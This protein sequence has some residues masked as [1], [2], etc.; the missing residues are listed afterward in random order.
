[1]AGSP[2]LRRRHAE[3]SAA[4][5]RIPQARAFPDPT[6][7]Y[8]ISPWTVGRGSEPAHE[9]TLSQPLQWPGKRGARSDAA[10]SD[11][12]AVAGDLGEEERHHLLE[13]RRIFAK[14]WFA[15]RRIALGGQARTLLERARDQALNAAAAGGPTAAVLEGEMALSELERIVL[16][17]EREHLATMAEINALAGRAADATV[18][19]PVE[20]LAKV[21]AQPDQALLLRLASR[22]PA[23]RAAEARLRAAEAGLR[24]S[25][26]NQYPDVTL[27]VGYTSMEERH[28]GDVFVGAGIALPLDR[29]LRRGAIDEASARLDAARAQVAHAVAE[30][31]RE[32]LDASARLDEGARALALLRSRTLPAAEQ[33]VVVA[34][35]AYA[36]GTGSLIDLVRAQR[37]RISVRLMEAEELS[38]YY[39]QLG[40]LECCIGVPVQSIIVDSPSGDQP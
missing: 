33:G 31:N 18:P 17:A 32:A 8:R 39:H 24:L 3:L 27:M 30:A 13:S 5:A 36:A 38:E 12:E 35:A 25:R 4:E 22:R 16:T 15:H 9:A 1:M 37:T 40:N 26:R 19:P 10:A 23:V 7:S 21:L 28:D 20:Q 11:A 2:E 34:E 29:R 6:I 14:Y